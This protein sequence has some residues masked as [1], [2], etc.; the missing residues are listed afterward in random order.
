MPI[1]HNEH[2]SIIFQQ[3]RI[4]HRMP[5]AFA[6][7]YFILLTTLY[8]RRFESGDIRLR[9]YHD[10]TMFDIVDEIKIRTKMMR[11]DN[12]RNIEK[13]KEKQKK[14]Q[15]KAIQELLMIQ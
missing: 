11:V 14:E 2:Q 8:G 6:E 5:K 9:D 12:Q 10:M 15:D 7:E 3:E 4:R 13:H 1:K